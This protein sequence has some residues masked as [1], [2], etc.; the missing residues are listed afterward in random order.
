M[1]LPVMWPLHAVHHAAEDMTVLSTSRHHPLDGFIAG[2]W[3]A[4]PAALVGFSPVAMAVPLM[5]SGLGKD[6]VIGGAGHDI[7]VGDD[8]AIARDALYAVQR[9]T[10]E[11]KALLGAKWEQARVRC[12]SESYSC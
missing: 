4:L 3:F 11:A 6:T 1:H 9:I 2:L 5:I 7:I 8:A 10:A 12:S